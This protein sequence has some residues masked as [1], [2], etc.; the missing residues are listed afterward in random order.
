LFKGKSGMATRRAAWDRTALQ[1]LAVSANFS[2]D[3]PPLVA[4]AEQC[5]APRDAE[6]NHRRHDGAGLGV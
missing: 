3:D 2:A 4:N 5:S 1:L 6:D